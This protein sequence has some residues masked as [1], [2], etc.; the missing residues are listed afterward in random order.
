ML[1]KWM[2]IYAVI[3]PAFCAQ[4]ATET[5][6]G[7]KW[8]YTVSNGKAS[9]YSGKHS[10]AIP[11]TTSGAITIPSTLGGYPVTRIGEYAFYTC[12]N[13]TSVTIPNDITS[14][15]SSAFSWCYALENIN[16]PNKVTN[17]GYFAFEKCI[18]LKSITIPNSVTNIGE[19]A[20]LDCSSLANVKIGNGMITIG[21]EAFNGC[22]SSLYD[23]DSHPELILVD[24]WVIRA[25]KKLSGDL[26]LT[27]IRGIGGWAFRAEGHELT[28]VTIPNGAVS[29]GDCAFSYIRSLKSVTIPN[30]VKYIGG[31]A[32]INARLTRVEIPNG[33]KYIGN[34]AF[35]CTCVE[36]VIIGSGVE[37][38]GDCAFGAH[39]SYLKNVTLGCRVKHIGDC[40]FQGRFES[41][42]IPA[43]VRELGYNAIQS[44]YLMYTRAPSHL[45]NWIENNGSSNAIIRDAY[46][47]NHWDGTSLVYYNVSGVFPEISVD[48]EIKAALEGAA[49][50]NL[51]ANITNVAEYAAYRKWALG[52]KD[53]TEAE[54]KQSPLSWLSYALDT[55]KLIS[56]NPKEEDLKINDFK[57]MHNVAEDG[58]IEFELCASIDEI[59]I[60][61]G[62]TKDNLNKI[63][64]IWGAETLE[65]L[66]NKETRQEVEPSTAEPSEGKVKFKYKLE[67]SVKPK[68]ERFFWFFEIDQGIQGSFGFQA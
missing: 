5:V 68:V 46:D 37:F 7:I 56:S 67:K 38:I 50:T 1:K 27:D 58:A 42:I 35:Y 25:K 12:Q 47:Y 44:D 40:A 43:S 30:S 39:Y 13:I 52:L 34:H 53:T 61:D 14:I 49:D 22:N 65:G 16:I 26:H 54:V 59:K 28:S 17:I 63:F 51:T 24:G 45:K 3:L 9:I 41:F 19:S 62:A 11:R 15:D 32:F 48:S 8:N 18:K 21:R 57:P 20:F 36:S 66:M 10:A 31:E 29:I 60:G 6:N 4:A 64:K 55:D 23:M 2:M 33:V